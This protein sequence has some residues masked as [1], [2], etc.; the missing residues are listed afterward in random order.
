MSINKVSFAIPSYNEEKRLKRCIKSACQLNWINDIYVVNHRSTD[1]TEDMLLNM[2]DFCSDHGVILRWTNEDRDWQK[3]FMMADLRELSVNSCLKNIVFVQDADFIF[4][5]NYNTMI[6]KIINI[7]E[8]HKNIY[9][10]Q[11]EIP[12]IR[13]DFNLKNGIITY[14]KECIMHMPIPRVVLRNKIKG[15][16]TGV[17]GRHYWLHPLDK[18]CKKIKTIKR[19]KNSIVSINIKPKNRM[20]FRLT[21]TDFFEAIINYPEKTSGWKYSRW[22]SEYKK[23]NLDWFYNK[24]KNK[25]L[26]N[27]NY[28]IIGEKYYS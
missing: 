1:N 8:N 20:D 18:N 6:K 25:R 5:K 19:L 23:S 9:A 13:K 3:D 2:K 24:K 22:L 21:M 11:Y 7:F 12:V 14:C 27:P 16:Q 17:R 15:K 10:V 26:N 28:N 4:G